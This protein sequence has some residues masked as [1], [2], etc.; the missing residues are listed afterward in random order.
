VPPRTE[1]CALPGYY[2]AISGNFTT[3]RRAQF[4]ATSRWHPQITQIFYSQTAQV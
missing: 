3:T 2:A 1:N 4:L